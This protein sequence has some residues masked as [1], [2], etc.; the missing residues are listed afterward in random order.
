MTRCDTATTQ[1]PVHKAMLLSESLVFSQRKQISSLIL[2]E[3][4][5]HPFFATALWLLSATS[6][7]LR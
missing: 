3:D 7:C 4:R 2:A 6:F 1:A 5:P